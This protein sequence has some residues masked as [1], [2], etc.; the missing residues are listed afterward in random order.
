MQRLVIL[1]HSDPIT[2]PAQITLFPLG[3]ITAPRHLFPALLEYV[4]LPQDI[5]LLHLDIV[6]LVLDTLHPHL[7]ITA[8]C[9]EIFLRLLGSGILRAVTFLTLLENVTM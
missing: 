3:T 1:Q 7:D 4:I 6:T 9:V 2:M 5:F 8:M